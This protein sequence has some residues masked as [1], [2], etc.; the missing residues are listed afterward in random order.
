MLEKTRDID[1]AEVLILCAVLLEH[2]LDVAPFKPRTRVCLEIREKIV[3]GLLHILDHNFLHLPASGGQLKRN[4]YRFTLLVH[5][6]HVSDSILFPAAFH[7]VLAQ[8]VD[9][10]HVAAE[11][12]NEPAARGAAFQESRFVS[13][14]RSKG[15]APFKFFKLGFRFINILL[16][17]FR[18]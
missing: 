9:L 4:V 15:A 18:I 10:D 11:V 5:G 7:E 2:L 14:N 17:G 1:I 16:K 12:R 13:Q 8:F 3:H 6:Q